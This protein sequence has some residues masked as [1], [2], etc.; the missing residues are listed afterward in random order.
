MADCDH[1]GCR[2]TAR[3][4]A[5]FIDIH[6][7][8]PSGPVAIHPLSLSI[9]AMVL[10]RWNQLKCER[11]DAVRRIDDMRHQQARTGHAGNKRI[12][13]GFPPAE[14]KSQKASVWG[15]DYTRRENNWLALGFAKAGRGFCSTFPVDWISGPRDI[16]AR[17]ERRRHTYCRAPGRFVSL[18]DIGSFF[19]GVF[20]SPV[21][22][23]LTLCSVLSARTHQTIEISSHTALLY[24][25]FPPHCFSTF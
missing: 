15:A 13:S 8:P 6:G 18:L 3:I 24:S 7:H 12:V 23:S 2:L 14:K 25:S 4:L 9:R 11:L 20:L 19:F 10:S 16:L 5:L 22:R 17:C 1:V 21:R